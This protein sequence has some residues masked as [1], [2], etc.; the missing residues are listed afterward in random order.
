VLEVYRDAYEAI[1]S[2]AQETVPREACGLL[3]GR[4]EGEHPVVETSHRARNVASAPRVGYRIDTRAQ[5]ALMDGIE[6]A[7]RTVVGIY[8]SHPAGPATLS[9]RDRREASWLGYH[10]VL[11]SLARSHPTLLAWRYTGEEFTVEPIRIVER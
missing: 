10:Y 4:R 2:H 6:A 9:E 1:L 11:V 3:A 8:H 7:G 5:L